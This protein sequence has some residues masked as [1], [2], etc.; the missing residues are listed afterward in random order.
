MASETPYN[1]YLDTQKIIVC[2]EHLSNPEA[3]MRQQAVSFITKGE[4]FFDF[5]FLLINIFRTHQNNTHI[6][7]EHPAVQNF[8]KN[9]IKILI[10]LIFS[11][12]FNEK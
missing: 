9:I 8:C 7:Q 11:L 3:N 12:F 10:F 6:T 4:K 2:M 1:E 5:P